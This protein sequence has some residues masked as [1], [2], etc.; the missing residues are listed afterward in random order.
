MI[1]KPRIESPELLILRCLSPRKQLVEKDH[2]YYENLEKGFEGEKKF[3]E[4]LET[5][6][7]DWLFLNGLLLEHNNSLFQ[8][9]T[10]GISQE[11]LYLFDV[12][13]YEGDMSIDGELW[14][15]S[16]GTVLKNP[17]HQLQRCESL[18]S[19]FL[20]DKGLHFPIKAY[21]VFNHPHF[22]LYGAPRNPT[23]IL[24]TQLQYFMKKL[25]SV[26]SVLNSSHKKLAD[27]ILTANL[28]SYPNAYI[29]K[30]EYSDLTR[31]II[32]SSCGSFLKS[33]SHFGKLT[34]QHCLHVEQLDSAAL[35]SLREFQI[36]FPER[37]VTTNALFDWCS[38]ILSKRQVQKVLS[39]NFERKGH[40]KYSYY[41]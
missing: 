3:D 23:I 33:K 26:K 41:V 39:E 30:Y 32:C 12:K 2:H 17:L 22:T 16:N 31:G 4:L 28:P 7:E 37:K 5:F 29:P 20:Q 9:D 18:L 19:R 27:M 36:L 40:G 10:L 34:C 24:P 15:Y 8:I 21:L 35:R 6:T 1:L 38:P 14:K 13:Y 11:G 25:K